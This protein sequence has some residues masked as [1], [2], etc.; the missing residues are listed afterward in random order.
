MYLYLSIYLYTYIP[1]SSSR[2]DCVPVVGAIFFASGG[3]HVYTC[4]YLSIYL[5]VCIY[6]PIYLSIDPCIHLYLYLYLY[7][8]IYLYTYI[9]LSSSRFDFVPVVGAIFFA[10]GGSERAWAGWLSTKTR[11]WASAR[12]NP[13][14]LYLYTLY[15]YI[16][17]L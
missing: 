3:A 13:I 14:C 8:S 11:C 5:S 7:L 9:P 12:A 6:L 1:L 17:I 16:S 15:I 2:F 4:I 10:S